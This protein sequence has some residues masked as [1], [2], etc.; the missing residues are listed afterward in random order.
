[1][2]RITQLKLPVGHTE[3]QLR[4]KLLKT[5]HIK[6]RGL[7]EYTIKKRSLDARKKPELYYV[8]TV[9]LSAAD[10]GAILRRL[11]GRY[12]RRKKR[13]TVRRNMGRFLFPAGLP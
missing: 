5:V 1:M 4:K 8:Y 7:K 11:K 9:D 3:E 6:E 13:L 2:L 10:E 12:R